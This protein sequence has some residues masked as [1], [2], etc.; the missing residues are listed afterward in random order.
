MNET[1]IYRYTDTKKLTKETRIYKKIV[2]GI[3][4]VQVEHKEHPK[5][6]SSFHHKQYH[7][8]YVGVNGGPYSDVMLIVRDSLLPVVVQRDVNGRF[9]VVEVNYEGKQIWV[10]DIYGSNVARKRMDLWRCLNQ[11]LRHGR[12]CFLLGDFN[13]C[14]EVGQST[15]MHGLMDAP[16]REV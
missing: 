2:N 5:S 7:D 16:E 11:V 13:M 6:G 12:S 15:S 8:F 10:V 14:H 9:L 4:Y 3:Y 1:Y